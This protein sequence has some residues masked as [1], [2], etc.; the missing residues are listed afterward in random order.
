VDKVTVFSGT[1]SLFPITT[2]MELLVDM[3]Q[4]IPLAYDILNPETKGVAL[5]FHRVLPRHQRSKFR[6]LAGLE[7]DFEVFKDLIQVFQKRRYKFLTAQMFAQSLALGDIPKKFVV[8]TFD[9]GYEDNYS[10]A[11]AYLSEHKIPWTLYLTSSMADHTMPIWWYALG[12]L[13][14]R[15]SKLDL[16]PFGL[17]EINTSG[18]STVKIDSLYKKL[19]D[20][21]HRDFAHQAERIS[22]VFQAHHIDPIAD[23][24]SLCLD[25]S[26]IKDLHRQNVEIANHTDSHGNAKEMTREAF[27][28][29][30]KTCQLKIEKHLGVKPT[31]F[32]YPFGDV[33]ACGLREFE[34]IRNLSFQLAFTTNCGW[35]PERSFQNHG[36]NLLFE[37]PR[38][39]VCQ[40]SVQK[41]VVKIFGANQLR[42][43]FRGIKSQ[44]SEINAS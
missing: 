40:S 7:L 18:L 3:L 37:L 6:D 17:G 38:I 24:T 2:A 44:R 28:H 25:W 13:I 21:L 29:D 19:R 27:E 34:I 35:L 8:I 10:L 23:Y 1:D 14:E 15:N 43:F 4:L 30:V 33:N 39:N 42:N 32:A 26:K 41:E 20:V 31:T 12:D 16:S 22:A 36:G 5:M 9:D 11:G